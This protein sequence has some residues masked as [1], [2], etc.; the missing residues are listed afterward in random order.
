[1][2]VRGIHKPRG[3]KRTSL[4][5]YGKIGMK[6]TNVHLSGKGAAVAREHF[7]LQG[8]KNPPSAKSIKQANTTNALIKGEESKI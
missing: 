6:T 4:K 5:L 1:M 8:K 3:R 2:N 7:A